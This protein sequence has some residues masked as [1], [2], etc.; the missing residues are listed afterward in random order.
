MTE[1]QKKGFF[2]VVWKRKGNGHKYEWSPS[3]F[4]F[5]N[6]VR[7]AKAKQKALGD[8]IQSGT[9]GVAPATAEVDFDNFVSVDEAV[10]DAKTGRYVVYKVPPPPSEVGPE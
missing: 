1:E 5:D 6:A 8:L 4:T 3:L 10:V 9:L 7:A 2:V